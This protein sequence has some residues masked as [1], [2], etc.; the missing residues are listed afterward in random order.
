MGF[1]W[2][3]ARLAVQNLSR[4]RGRAFL[5][6]LA[7]AVGGGA[8]FAAVVV[9]QGLAESARLGLARMGADVLVVPR[10]ATVNIT[11][12]LLTV[13]PSTQTLPAGV[14]DT[15]AQLPGVLAVAPQR[16]HALTVGEGGHD[17]EDLIAFDPARDFT[18]IP[19]LTDRL[20]RPLAAGDILVGARRAE[21]VGSEINLFGRSFTVYGKLA[22][23]GVGPFE[24]SL[25]ASFQ[26]VAAVAEAA[27]QTTSR[28]ILD[29]GTDKYSGV[30]VQLAAG[31]S[32]EQFRFAAARVPDVKIV[33]ANALSMSVR[34]GLAT[35]LSAAVV[36]TILILLSTALMVAAMYSGLL[37]ER[38]RE[39]GLF[40]AIGLRPRELE[41]MIL[42]EAALTTG[43]GGVAGVLLGVAALLAFRRSLGYYFERL[44]VPFVLPTLSSVAIAATIAILLAGIVGAC[45]ALIPARRVARGEPYDLVRGEA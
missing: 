23:T 20:D 28:A 45:G 39:L 1:R 40:L 42:A 11:A 33:P 15:L 38:R 5:M 3:F 24:R 18:I 6:A 7:V 36:L 43:C 14:V 35:I 26:T 29:A 16:Y 2:L 9:R 32:V 12:A 17:S 13:E 25:F 22:L 21:R 37:V 27:R 31:T 44:Q 19:W 8:V 30:L 34:R 4:R 41:R 10:D